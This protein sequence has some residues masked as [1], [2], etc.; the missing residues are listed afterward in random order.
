MLVNKFVRKIATLLCGYACSMLNAAL[1]PFFFQVTPIHSV[2]LV[3]MNHLDI[4][5]T[6]FINP[7][8]NEYIHTYYDRAINLSEAMRV[9]VVNIFV[10]NLT[11][12]AVC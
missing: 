11:V 6:N 5:Y 10:P 4:G 12:L 1:F 2:H 3:F 9:V 8:Y 7:V